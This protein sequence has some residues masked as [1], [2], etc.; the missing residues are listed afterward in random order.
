MQVRSLASATAKQ[1][2]AARRGLATEWYAA[3]FAEEMSGFDGVRS[4]CTQ[5]QR[6]NCLKRLFVRHQAR[7]WFGKRR[8]LCTRCGT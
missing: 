7:C 1:H 4:A 8:L 3:D 5:Q 6:R 2:S